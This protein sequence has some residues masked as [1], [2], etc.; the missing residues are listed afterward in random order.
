[1]L[2]DTNAT[3][4]RFQ[5]KLICVRKCLM[6]FCALACCVLKSATR[7]VPNVASVLNQVHGQSLQTQ[8]TPVVKLIGAALHIYILTMIKFFSA[9]RARPDVCDDTQL[10]SSGLNND[11]RLLHAELVPVIK[12]ES[13]SP[14]GTRIPA[15]QT[16]TCVRYSQASRLQS[17]VHIPARVGHVNHCSMI[18]PKSESIYVLFSCRSALVII[19]HILEAFP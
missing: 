19:L 11:D 6:S 17:C 5:I 1:L 8:A 18:I 7:G 13:Y 4:R 14:I 3:N 12:C 16:C 2:F 10:H 15:F 9:V